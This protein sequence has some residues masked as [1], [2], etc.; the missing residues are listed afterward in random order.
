MCKKRALVKSQR[1]APRPEQLVRTGKSERGRGMRL[2]ILEQGKAV[3][4]YLLASSN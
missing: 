4:N 1:K 2:D 3:N